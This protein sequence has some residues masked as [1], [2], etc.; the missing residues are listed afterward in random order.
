MMKMTMCSLILDKEVAE[1]RVF[2]MQYRDQYD[3]SEDPD[4][5]SD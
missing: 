1:G 2:C 4:R 5:R 3:A